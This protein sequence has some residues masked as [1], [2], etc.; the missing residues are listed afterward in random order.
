M[1]HSAA[2]SREDTGHTRS[3]PDLPRQGKRQRAHP[4]QLPRP[5]T[6]SSKHDSTVLFRGAGS[7]TRS[8]R[9]PGCTPSLCPWVRTPWEPALPAPSALGLR[10]APATGSASFPAEQAARRR[11]PP[12]AVEPARVP[13]PRFPGTGSPTRHGHPRAPAPRHARPRAPPTGA[14]TGDLGLKAHERSRSSSGSGQ[15]SCRQPRTPRAGQMRGPT[16]ASGHLA[17]PPARRAAHVPRARR[18]GAQGPWKLLASKRRHGPSESLQLWAGLG[19]G[20]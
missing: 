10:G 7:A 3:F 12:A 15:G 14:P 6:P 19:S 2:G 8:T 13:R 17:A 9:S 16:A 4:A 11:T 20:F 1:G 18:R 5:H